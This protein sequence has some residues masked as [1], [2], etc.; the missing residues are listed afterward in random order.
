MSAMGASSAAGSEQ[1]YT[2]LRELAAGYLRR[3]RA[4]H[5]LQ[6]TALVHEAFIR[7]LSS[8]G[9]G[10]MTGRELFCAAA[11]AM[12]HV[13]V[14]SARRHRTLKRTPGPPSATLPPIDDIVAA[15]GLSG[16]DVIALDQ[17]LEHLGQFDPEL[18]TMVE[19]RFFGGLTEE[20]TARHLGVSTRTVTRSWRFARAWLASQIERG[21]P[22]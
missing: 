14:D 10:G 7:L 20:Q 13:L 21:G 22:R 6:P 8:G 3:E 9:I 15:T 12:R 5:T 1:V 11:R 17:A 18:L 19:L 16:V 2:R 4:G